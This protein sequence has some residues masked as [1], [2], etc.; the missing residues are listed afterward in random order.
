MSR[1]T[2][3][4]ILKLLLSNLLIVSFANAQSDTA[5]SKSLFEP[6]IETSFTNNDTHSVTIDIHKLEVI[7]IKVEEKQ[8]SFS[9]GYL[10][11][12]EVNI[13]E[14][15][16]YRVTK[17][18]SK[19]VKRKTK[20]KNEK[21]DNEYR[22]HL[23]KIPTIHPS[24]IATV[25]SKLVESENNTYLKVAFELDT[26][27]FLTPKTHKSQSVIVKKYLYNFA[28]DMYKKT[29]VEY[30]LQEKEKLRN[31]EIKLKNLQQV[32]EKHH[33]VVKNNEASILNA[34]ID[35]Q[36]NMVDQERIVK[37][38]ADQKREVS[39]V[40]KDAEAKKEAKKILREMEREKRKLQ[41]QLESYNKKL[42]KYRADIENS[43]RLITININ[44]QAILER[45]IKKQIGFVKGLEKKRRNI[46]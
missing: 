28:I 20:F 18:W 1:T 31:Q 29:V 8:D 2:I 19:Y 14:N 6:K 23:T 21:Y 32:N 13:P 7:P 5:D 43:K 40:R 22:I 38:I 3:N 26:G 27:V 9:A 44:D 46:K 41:S 24:P 15:N 39:R 16:V 37:E 35:I 11:C 12:L 25:F 10:F 34:N 42:V 36:A 4:R 45:L 33:R 17:S 30:I